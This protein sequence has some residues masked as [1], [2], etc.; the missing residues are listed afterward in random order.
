MSW[1]GRAVPRRED[2]RILRGGALYVDDLER[3]GLLHA[4]FVRSPHARAR[5]LARRASPT[6]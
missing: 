4:A 2:E 6:A 5:I 1:I 3:K